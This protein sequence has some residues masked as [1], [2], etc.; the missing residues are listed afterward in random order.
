MRCVICNRTMFRPARVTLG[1]HP[2]GPTCARR[3][4]E[5]LLRRP[6]WPVVRDARTRDLFEEVG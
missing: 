5:K 2:V 6:A 4:G 3:I 1:G